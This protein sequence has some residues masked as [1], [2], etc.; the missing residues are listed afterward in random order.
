MVAVDE[1]VR[2]SEVDKESINMWVHFYDL[3]KAMMKEQFARKL[4]V[5]LGQVLRVDTSFLTYLR[6]RVQF[7]LSKALVPEI[8]MKVKG[9]GD[10]PVIVRY[11]NVTHF[12][13][14]C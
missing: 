12:C 14:V 10:L 1:Y 3:P 4:G 2:P 6:V 8:R 7:L 11:E 5:S 9:K 13:F